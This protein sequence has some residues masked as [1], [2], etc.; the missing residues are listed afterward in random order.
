VQ[1]LIYIGAVAILMM[2]GI[3]LTRNIQG[4]DTTIV[5]R[6]WKIPAAIVAF[7]VVAVLFVGIGE[8]K[9]DGLTVSW[10]DTT[11]RPSILPQD[12][13]D[14]TPQAL[15]INDMGKAI[16]VEMMTRYVVPFELAGLLLTAAVVGAIALAKPE[17]TDAVMPLSNAEE[18]ARSPISKGIDKGV[19]AE[20]VASS[21]A[22]DGSI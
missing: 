3:M 22:N 1:V 19:P 2:F 10:S 18:I 14:K 6:G 11:E 21:V 8:Q 9:G 16:G 12:G 17:D 20:L 7:G 5:P 13:R 4:D 15:A